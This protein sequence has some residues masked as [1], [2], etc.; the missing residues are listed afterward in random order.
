[1]AIPGNT[2]EREQDK[3]REGSS[4]KTVVATT[5]DGPPIPVNVG[6]AWDSF[7]ATYPNSTTEVY[8]FFFEL[9]LVQTITLVYQDESKELLVSG[10]KV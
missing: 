7:T 8:Q 1:M 2:P 10:A 5:H 6:V 9:S 3:F 4:G